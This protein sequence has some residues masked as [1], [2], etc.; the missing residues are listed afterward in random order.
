M[1]PLGRR[2]FY[3][4]LRNICFFFKC[5][6]QTLEN[7]THTFFILV[8]GRGCNSIGFPKV[9]VEG[10]EPEHEQQLLHLSL[11]VPSKNQSIRN[12]THNLCLPFDEGP[13]STLSLHTY[14]L[15]IQCALGL[16][17]V[18]DG[19]SRASQDHSTPQVVSRGPQ[20][21]RGSGLGFGMQGSGQNTQRLNLKH[22]RPR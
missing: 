15:L 11:R 21:S 5:S 6:F 20:A 1:V 2:C 3:S 19:Y 9:P 8:L 7:I 22:L 14:T 13:Y 18:L 17:Q 4:L 16:M 10:L 12:A